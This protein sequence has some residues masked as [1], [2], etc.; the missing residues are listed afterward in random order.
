MTD[1][2]AALPGTYGIAPKGHRLSD[3]TRLGVVRLQVADLERS[4]A[5]YQGTLGLRVV[6]RD[7]SHAVLAAQG[8]DNPLVELHER[9]GARP[10]AHRGQLGLYHFAIL[11]PDRPSLGRFMRHLGQIGARAGA[12]DHLVSEALY[13]QDPDNLGIEVYADRPRDS[14]Q[15]TGRELVMAAD[16]IDAGGLAQAAGDAAWTGMPAGTTIGHVHL[17]VGD[18]EAAS[19][20]FSDALGFDRTVWHYPGALFLGA[21]GYHH[22][23]GANTWAGSG[24]TPPHNGDARLLEWTIEVP[25]DAALAS[26]QD[27]IRRGGYAAERDASDGSQLVTRDPWGT[28]IRVRV[29]RAGR[30]ADRAGMRR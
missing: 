19:A 22:H 9:T 1:A 15:R 27:S 13:L 16:P 11:L 6:S 20:F 26:L 2:E 4:L 23:L 5:Y 24:A 18:L 14:W 3:A 10:A 25:D 21:G 17:H 12:A 30:P 7:A 29:A 28:P 8:D